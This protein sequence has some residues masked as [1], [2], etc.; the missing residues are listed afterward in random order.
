MVLDNVVEEVPLNPWSV[1]LTKLPIRCAGDADDGCGTDDDSHLSHDHRTVYF[2][3]DRV[4]PPAFPAHSGASPAKFQASGKL[5]LD[6]R[7]DQR[8]VALTSP[9]G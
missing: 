3:S 4:F 1:C 7:L 5:R 8:M 9:P 2:S 6:Y